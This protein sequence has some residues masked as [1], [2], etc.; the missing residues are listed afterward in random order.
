[1]KTEKPF[2]V[3]LGELEALAR[4]QG[5]DFFP[6]NFEVIPQDI[7]VEIAAYGLPTRAQHWSYGKIYN[8]QRLFGEMGLSKIYE[9]V[10]NNDPGLAFLL[11]SNPDI[12]NLL[13]GAHVFGH[14]DF[15]KNNGLFAPTDR[16]M[17]N[18]A[19]SNALRVDKHIERYGLDV[20][21]HLQDIGFALDRHIDPYAG[22]HRDLYPVRKIAEKEESDLPYAD[23][24]GDSKPGVRYVVENER[25]PPHP[26]RDLLWFLIHY[27]NL[28][29]WQRDTLGIIREES[30]YFYPQFLTKIM[31]EGWASYWHAEL[32]HLW[33]EVNAGEMIEFARLHAGVVN[34]GSRYQ[35]NPYFLGYKI[36]VDIEE[37]WDKKR[38]EWIEKRDKG[39]KTEG[40]MPLT[41][42]EKLFEVRRTEDDI[43]FIRNYFTLDLAQKF[44]LFTYSDQ[45][46]PGNPK[47]AAKEA[48]IVVTSRDH[49][50]II[51]ALVAP[52]YNYGVPQ[53]WIKDV[54]NN[55]L[56]LEHANRATSFL[57]RQFA[58]MTLAYIGELWKH[59][60]FLLTHDE[61]GKEVYLTSKPTS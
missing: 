24:I 42:R 58:T 60:V 3:R 54:V 49:E 37:Q 9:I 2:A 23:I 29:D 55:H 40:P 51:E 27:A 10:L 1:M 34:P 48:T 53:I 30:Y 39:E 12:A 47:P 17:V 59:P 8:S 5:L 35:L 19:M 44:E 56:Y 16:N 15:F 61:A 14:V 36:L 46:P 13:V 31:N 33:E 50:A 7:M 22:V 57:D 25:I 41:G 52:R 4:Q 18:N 28:E 6:V 38:R 32:F 11:D 26:E 43:S 45:Q 21:E 20:V